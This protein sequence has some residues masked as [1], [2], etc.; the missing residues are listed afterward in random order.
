M[1][2]LFALTLSSIIACAALPTWANEDGGLFVEP[3]ITYQRQESDID[4]P[5]PFADSTAKV[6]G[7]GLMGR[8]GFHVSEALFIAGDFRY[9][10]PRYK[11]S[12]T[13]YNMNASQYDLGPTFGLQMPNLG[14]RVWG[15]YIPYA[16]LD[17]QGTSNLNY[18]FRDGKGYRVGVGFR[19]A[20]V[21]L[22]LEYENIKYGQTEFENASIF[23]GANA[24]SLQF[25][26]KSWIASVSFPLEM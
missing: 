12:A 25:D 20:M 11:D 23:S 7:L 19:V 16:E 8:A 1:K 18:W 24:D 22:N 26:G 4:N 21:S 5:T 15:T 17:P 10:F 2:T 14:F 3:G 9:S 6:E 13:N